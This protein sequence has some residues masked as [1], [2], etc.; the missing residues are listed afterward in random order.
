LADLERHVSNP[1]GGPYA[2]FSKLASGVGN[3]ELLLK[4]DHEIAF[5]LPLT[6]DDR[7]PKPFINAPFNQGIPHL[8]PDGRW[9]AYQS[10]ESGQNQI[11]VQ[12]FPATG[13]RI[14]VDPGTQP[15]W[16]G[17]GKELIFVSAA[18][19]LMSADIK[20]TASTLEA[21]TPKRLFLL[22]DRATNSIHFARDGQ[23]I[24][25]SAPTD[26][27]NANP[28]AADTAPLT[29]VTNWT[30]AWQGGGTK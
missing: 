14:S 26:A 30:A 27:L 15:R 22:P 24:L 19:V 13:Q 4:F 17:D 6:G 29:V 5:N 8:S 9:V 11:Y 7:T 18:R 12:P 10:N 20:T 2:I 21:G 3:E 1:E 23:R 28:A 16:R 25:V